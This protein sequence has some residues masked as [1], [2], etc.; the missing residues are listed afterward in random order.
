MS[1]KQ[2]KRIRR[3]EASVDDIYATLSLHTQLLNQLS[4]FSGSTQK[5]N[6]ALIKY[7]RERERDTLD[8]IQKADRK[9]QR[10]AHAVVTVLSVVVLLVVLLSSTAY[11]EPTAAPEPEHEAPACTVC[12][13]MPKPVM[14]L[15][16]LAGTNLLE[17]VTVTHY[18]ICPLCCGKQPDD[19]AYG[20]TASGRKAEP[21]VSVAVDPD[22]IPLGSTVIVDYG[23]GELHTYRADDTG[24]AVKGAHID[25]CMADH[26]AALQAGVKTATAW[27]RGAER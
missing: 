23:D 16:P 10:I 12:A 1:A 15:D 19:P 27:W 21:G 14:E 6:D 24:G 3:L 8:G 17:D 18:C 9:Q 7:I 4:E 5:F 20:I 26:E 22:V 13:A 25:I 11:A 2:C